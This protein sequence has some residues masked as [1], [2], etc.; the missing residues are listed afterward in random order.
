MTLSPDDVRQAICQALRPG[1][2]FLA[3]DCCLLIKPEPREELFWEVLHGRLLDG[4][5]TRER[6]AF[7]SWNVFLDDPTGGEPVLSVKLDGQHIFVSRAIF[8]HAWEGYD[9]GNN[10]FLSRETRKWLRE[11]IA[12]VDLADVASP[13]QLEEKL[14]AGLF[15][16]VI[17]VSRLPLTSIEAPLPGFSL[18]ELAY[19]PGA[20]ALDEPM[21]SWRDLLERGLLPGRSP[22]EWA[23]L[24]EIVLRSTAPAKLPDAARGFAARWQTLGQA[25]EQIPALLQTLFSEVALSPYTSFVTSTLEF[26]RRLEEQ[27]TLTQAARVDF[28][29]CLLRQLARHLTAY[30]LVKFHHRGANYPD[31]L[32]LDEVLKD[33]LRIIEGCPEL[34][35][36]DS[37]AEQRR[38]GAL[39]QGC[40]LRRVYEGLAVPDVPT[41]P[42][43][44]ARVLPPPHVRVPEDQIYD[45]TRRTRRLYA[46]DPLPGHLGPPARQALAQ[47][48]VDLAHPHELR[49]LG[50]AL[51]LDRPLAV[52]KRP[53]Q[54]DQ[55]L[56]LSYLAFSRTVADKRLTDLVRLL[57]LGTEQ[58]DALRQVLRL[59]GF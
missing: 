46:D 5:Q 54:P 45:P 14:K 24:L 7:E 27:G 15:Q 44:N 56:L 36:G 55:S 20:E 59:S 21:R 6:R 38:R 22:M 16:A 47:S 2:F 3:N 11:L 30:D 49:E 33:Y 32:L 40:L 31:A 1:H 4:S 51:F 34:F 58:A 50:L 29:A 28:L 52:G 8:C 35:A 10:V 18:G 13:A 42:G 53:G 41:S 23:K 12:D 39:R 37:P 25:A 26:L 48:L 43:E 9:S 57:D 19:F 17:G